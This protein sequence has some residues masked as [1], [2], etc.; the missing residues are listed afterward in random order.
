MYKIN[1]KITLNTHDKST[2]QD[3][4]LY[5]VKSAFLF[6]VEVEQEIMVFRV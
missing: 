3:F 6:N 5:I 2:F 1:P 4:W